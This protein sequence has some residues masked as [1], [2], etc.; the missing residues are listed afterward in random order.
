MDV[1]VILQANCICDN[2]RLSA[3]LEGRAQGAGRRI[4]AATA[5]PPRARL[6]PATH[7]WR[8][9]KVALGEGQ[10]RR[11]VALTTLSSPG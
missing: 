11:H 10:T 9:R 5:S 1:E 8:R 2:P 4:P 3:E 6:S 7:F